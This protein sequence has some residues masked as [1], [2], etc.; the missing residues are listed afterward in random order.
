[1]ARTTA[2]VLTLSALFSIQVG[3]AQG[4]QCPPS[5]CP[6]AD[7]DYIQLLQR[8][9]SLH[10][11]KEAGQGG[12]TTHK[13][14]DSR[15]VLHPLLKQCG[16]DDMAGRK[17]ASIMN[18]MS[19]RGED[20]RA[21]S[22][23][24]KGL[25]GGTYIELGAFNGKKFSNTYMFKHKLNWKGILVEADPDSFE[26]LKQNRKDGEIALEHMAICSKQMMVHWV[27]DNPDRAT[28]GIHEFMSPRFLHRWHPQL[29]GIPPSQL[30]KASGVTEVPCNTM[31]SILD[32]HSVNHIDLFSLDVE[33]AELE[34]LQ[35]VDFSRISFGLLI[36][37]SN[38][39][40]AELKAILEPHGYKYVETF[41]SVKGN[42][43]F[44]NANFKDWYGH[45]PEAAKH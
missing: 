5:G 2:A 7:T 19:Q 16:N 24:F 36:I 8:R 6:A 41:P 21:E 43:W 33:G 17:G 12:E 39:H 26:Q 34:V 28:H 44:V 10:A 45:N 23:Y 42:D 40:T 15:S 27:A 11:T 30:S 20:V 3:D 22:G 9:A 32:K 29:E 25:C 37:E 38:N 4:A 18:N 14:T 35:S 31:T 1:M 13:V